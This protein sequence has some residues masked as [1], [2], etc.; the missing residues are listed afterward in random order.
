MCVWCA[1]FLEKYICEICDGEI[2]NTKSNRQERLKLFPQLSNVSYS[3][4][5][6]IS[7]LGNVSCFSN[8][9]GESKF[10]KQESYLFGKLCTHADN[11]LSAM[12][13]F[14]YEDSNTSMA[15]ILSHLIV[16]WKPELSKEFPRKFGQISLIHLYF[17][18]VQHSATFTIF[19]S[20]SKKIL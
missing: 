8:F 11:S 12:T 2:W 3:G 20:L 9:T 13:C 10:P 7:Y 6:L 15:A 17:S 14:Y 5:F 19:Q 16:F 4:N 1:E 18:Q